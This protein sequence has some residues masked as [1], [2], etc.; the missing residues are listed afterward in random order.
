MAASLPS[1]DTTIER[2]AAGW[3]NDPYEYFGCHNTRIQPMRRLVKWI[4]SEE[5]LPGRKPFREC[6][7]EEIRVVA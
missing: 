3:K 5:L 4:I 1:R 6:T 7:D 2:Q